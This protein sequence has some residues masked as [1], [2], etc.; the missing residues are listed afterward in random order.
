MSPQNQKQTDAFKKAA[1]KLDTNESDDA[2]DLIM[3]KLD[4]TKKPEP[5]QKSFAPREGEKNNG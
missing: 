1:R 2:L 5:D 4:L 3:R